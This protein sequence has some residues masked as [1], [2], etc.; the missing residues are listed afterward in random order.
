[1]AEESARAPSPGLGPHLPELSEAERA[2]QLFVGGIDD[3]AILLLDASGRVRSWNSGARRIKG[4]ESQEIIGRH[5]S[6]FYP[7]EAVAKGW[8]D[9]ELQMAVQRGRFADEG[10]RLRKDGTRFWASVVITAL[11]P[12]DRMGTGFLKI[13]RD[14]SERRAAEEALRHSEERHR[15]LVAGVR[16]YA[17]FMLSP[18]GLI[19]SWNSG[20]ERIKGYKA[21]EIIGRHFSCLYPPEAVAK[22]L[23]EW[24]LETATREGSVENEGWRLT[25]SGGRFWANVVITALFKEDGAVQGFAKITR[26]MSDRHRLED[27]L[28]VDRQKN[29]FLA[30]LTQEMRNPLAPIRSAL[31]V[32]GQADLDARSSALVRTIAVRQVDHLTRLLDDLLDVT[33]V[34]RGRIELR[35]ERVDIAL[36]IR[37]AVEAASPLTVERRHQVTVDVPR[38]QLWVQ[39]DPVR[40]E[41]IFTNLILNA[42]K[43]TEAQGR[44]WIAARNEAGQVV[45]RVRDN[46]IGIDPLV[47]SR[48]F[49]L[50]VQAERHPDRKSGGP[51]IGLTLVRRLVE[52]HR[53]TVEVMSAGP[54]KGSEFVVSLPAV[55]APIGERQPARELQHHESLRVLVVDDNVDAADSL[56]MALRLSG[57]E[58][59]VAYDG[60]AAL[61]I[62]AETRPEAVLLDIGMPVMD[63]YL[64]AR[65]LRETAGTEHALL[66]AVTGW[67]QD[68]HRRMSKE[69]GFDYH[70][71]KPVDPSTLMPLIAGYHDRAGA[72]PQH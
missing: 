57:Q 48:I 47:A 24:E 7:P 9:Y 31:H 19:S 72:R 1:M 22:G 28:R 5:F 39:A 56:A 4:Y 49:D 6:A 68:D 63:G 2:L 62:A 16:E 41:Q 38:N 40:L 23:P 12:S 25:K 59:R 61:A 70:L 43:F 29:E 35:Q 32:L 13:T 18:E 64:V 44:I 34:A 36:A 45:I 27:L 58:V 55:E 14:L 3:Y 33:Q 53:G 50:F 54:G 17:I 8:P 30:L 60:A 52:L 37:R 65:R 46:G 15:L 11:R 21:A 10:W 67:G 66:I 51:G 42:A 20:A 69:A 26:D 71:V